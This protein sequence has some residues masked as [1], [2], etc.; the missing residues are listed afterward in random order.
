MVSKN[1][2]VLVTGAGG[3]IGSHLVARL[4]QNGY[5]VTAFVHYNSR[6]DIGLLRHADLSLM[7]KIRVCFGDL[8]DTSA[9]FSAMKGQEVVYHLGALIGIPYSYV[10]PRDVFE[11]NVTGTL[12]VMMAAKELGVRRIVHTSTSE[13]YGT[14]KMEK[15]SEAHPLQ[16]QS[17]YSAS[18]IGADKLI[19]SFF[20]SY[21]LPVV[22]LR[23][24]NTYG[25]C[26]SMRAIIPTIIAQALFQ[27]EIH[28]G[29]LTPVRDFTFVEDAIDAFLLG[30][31]VEGIEGQ[32]FN[33]GTDSE[34]SIQEIVQ[35]VLALTDALH[36]PV[37]TDEQ[38]VRPEKSEVFRLRSDYSKAKRILGWEPK[39]S[40]ETGLQK[41]VEWIKKHPEEYS[42]THYVI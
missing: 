38:R 2:K 29:S 36:K 28:V 24:F 25:P 23:P 18:K 20:S 27:K 30:G 8:K 13:V 7:E 42:K 21:Q 14:A 3:F 16:G 33:L 1:C 4:V 35:K 15:I 22:T 10:N 11:T 31:S 17:P 9:V 6:G 37:K 12:N 19:E 5:E 32:V 26:Q 40:L 41:T 39:T 34:I